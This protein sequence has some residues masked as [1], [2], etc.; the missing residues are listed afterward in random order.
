MQ[1]KKI[2][3][4]QEERKL[5]EFKLYQYIGMQIAMNQFLSND[6]FEY[7][8]DHYVRLTNSFSEKY[9]LLIEYIIKLLEERD[10]KHIPVQILNYRYASGSLDVSYNI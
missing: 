4:V 9:R 7:S 3:L 5:F 10:K 1:R 2:D 6:Q 8:E